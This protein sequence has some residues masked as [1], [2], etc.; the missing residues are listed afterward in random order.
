MPVG[1]VCK[2]YPEGERQGLHAHH[3]F[4]RSRK[5]TRHMLINGVTLC[6]GHHMWAHRQVLDFHEWM[7]GELGVEYDELQQLSRTLSKEVRSKQA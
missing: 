1:A 7:R 6:M 4:T 5:S 2:F 3:V